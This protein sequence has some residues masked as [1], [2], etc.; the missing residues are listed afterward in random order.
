MNLLSISI[1]I[2]ALSTA[3]FS[4]PIT[5]SSAAITCTG[6][7]STLYPCSKIND[8]PVNDMDGLPASRSF[9]LGRQ[10]TAL[11]DHNY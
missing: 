4:A 10:M 1:C 11:G 5:Y 6:S 2:L 3:V 8:D 7:Y 9:W